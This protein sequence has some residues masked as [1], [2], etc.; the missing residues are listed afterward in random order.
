MPVLYLLCAFLRLLW[1]ILSVR[2][3]SWRI[4]YIFNIAWEMLPQVCFLFSSKILL[5]LC[6]IA[7]L[8][9]QNLFSCYTDSWISHY[10]YL[11]GDSS[12]WQWQG[13]KCFQRKQ[14]IQVSGFGLCDV[15]SVPLY[16]GECSFFVWYDNRECQISDHHLFLKNM[17]KI[18]ESKN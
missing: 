6:L 18:F 16:F 11:L 4:L 17:K 2:W 5:K 12:C 15:R 1:D 3:K 14:E 10:V 7:F 13:I 8:L 9:L